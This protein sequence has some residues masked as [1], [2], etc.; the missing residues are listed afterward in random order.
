MAAH[1]QGEVLLAWL[2]FSDGQGAKRR[3][4]LVVRDFDDDD[5]LVVPITSHSARGKADAS[6][7]SGEA[8]V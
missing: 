8:P 3:P 5:L 1:A 4:A 7:R 2:V 6:F